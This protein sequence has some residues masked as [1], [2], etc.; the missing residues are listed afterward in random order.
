MDSK[1]DLRPIEAERPLC[2]LTYHRSAG[3]K[4][5]S[6]GGIAEDAEEE[7]EED[8]PVPNA[9]DPAGLITDRSPDERFQLEGMIAK[10]PLSLSSPGWPWVHSD[11]DL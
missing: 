4:K 1:I 7:E 3:Q 9:T 11:V 5:H 8:T 6:L 2:L 10:G